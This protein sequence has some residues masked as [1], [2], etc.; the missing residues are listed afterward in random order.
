MVSK[1]LNWDF[2]LLILEM[3]LEKPK[4]TKQGSREKKIKWWNLKNEEFELKFITLVGET[5]VN[6]SDGSTYEVVERAIIK[7]A[8]R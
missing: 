1:N 5:S 3:E 6:D 7:T 8:R 4:R 2:W